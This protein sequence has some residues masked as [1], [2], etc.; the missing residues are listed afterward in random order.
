VGILKKVVPCTH[1]QVEMGSGNDLRI[2]IGTERGSRKFK[3]DHQVRGS[4][5]TH[6]VQTYRRGWSAS[7]VEIR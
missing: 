7:R 3:G 1:R 2:G 5:K 6:N 4:K